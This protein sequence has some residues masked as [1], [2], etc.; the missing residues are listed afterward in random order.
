MP[1]LRHRG[2]AA[3]PSALTLALTA[4]LVA[5]WTGAGAAAPAPSAR[6]VVERTQ[7][8]ALLLGPHTAMSAPDNHSVALQLVGARRPITGERTALPVIGHETGAGGVRWLHVLLPGRP[9]GHSGWIDKRGTAAAVTGWHIV[10]DTAERRVTVYQNGRAARTFKAVV[11]KPS[12]PTPRGEFFV[13]EAIQLRPSD[14]GAPFAL[15]LSARS[16]VLQEFDGGPG[17]IAL[18]GLANIGGVLGSADSHG[19][20]RLDNSAMRWLVA[21]IGPGVPVTIR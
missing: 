1:A 17:Q 4:S 6:P 20:V 5:V 10:V 2:R 19:C 12:T 21:R 18:H 3:S 7:E 13:E 8:L 9:N 15:A 11:G 14:V 16:D